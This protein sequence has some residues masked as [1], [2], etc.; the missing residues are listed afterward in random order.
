MAELSIIL[1]LPNLPPEVSSA[2][3]DLL[4]SHLERLRRPS[5]PMSVKVSVREDES[6]TV[7]IN[8]D[9]SAIKESVK[10]EEFVS[11]PLRALRSALERLE[12]RLKKLKELK[13]EET[14]EAKD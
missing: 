13:T 11:D 7:R 4:I 5:R 3:R 1:S 9:G 6:Y 10:A 8:L 2:A 12:K 14:T